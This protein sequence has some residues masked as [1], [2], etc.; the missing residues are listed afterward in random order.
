MKRPHFKPC[1]HGC[2]A[3]KATGQSTN[4]RCNFPN[5]DILREEA[6]ILW[7][8]HGYTSVG[9]FAKKVLSLLDYIEEREEPP[10]ERLF[11]ELKEVMG[12]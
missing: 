5:I 12:R 7:G 2:A 9:K 6:E 8:F 4:G 10:A 3:R 1:N 11:D